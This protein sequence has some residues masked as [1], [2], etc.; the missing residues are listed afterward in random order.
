MAFIINGICICD[1]SS[2]NG[3]GNGG[4]INMNDQLFTF[5]APIAN[6]Q[7]ID[8]AFAPNQIVDIQYRNGGLTR[9]IDYQ[10]NGTQFEF[11]FPDPGPTVEIPYHLYIVYSY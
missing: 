9:G 4:S 7:T 3:G 10:V 2:N 8:L 11:L 6:G 5:N 1:S